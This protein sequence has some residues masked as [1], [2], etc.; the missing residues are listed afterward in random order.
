ME[1]ILQIAKENSKHATYGKEEYAQKVFDKIDSIIED[2]SKYKG[3]TGII[4]AQILHSPNAYQ[5]MYREENADIND[6]YKFTHG[7]DLSTLQIDS[8]YL[9]F[10]CI[11][12]H[13][14]K[15]GFLTGI[16]VFTYMN[17]IQYRILLSW[18][19]NERV[20]DK[21]NLSKYVNGVD[22]YE[23]HPKEPY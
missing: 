11:I 14:A 2:A 15:L 20:D 6:E 9:S 23:N 18:S 17:D 19:D 7:Y 4:I 21:I 3:V 12:Q 13:Y 16:R 22:I 1:N 8:N 10:D 5:V